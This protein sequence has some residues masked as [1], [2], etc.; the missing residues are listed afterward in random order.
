MPF[1]REGI[2]V[3]CD[4]GVFGARFLEGVVECEEAGEVFGIGNEG[5]PDFS[6]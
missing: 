3:E 6:R 5:C 4:E 1:G 2:S